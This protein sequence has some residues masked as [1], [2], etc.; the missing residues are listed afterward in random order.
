V[1]FAANISAARAGVIVC[2]LLRNPHSHHQ[3]RTDRPA[4]VQSLKSL[5][6]QN[7]AVVQLFHDQ[8]TAGSNRRLDQLR[9]ARASACHKSP[10]GLR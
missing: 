9:P 8:W 10:A 3:H 1:L 4:I 5:P 7:K 6:E 2:T